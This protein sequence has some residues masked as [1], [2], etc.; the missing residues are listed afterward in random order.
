MK[1]SYTEQ[2]AECKMLIDKHKL[3]LKQI[4]DNPHKEPKDFVRMKFLNGEID[5][6]DGSLQIKKRRLLNLIN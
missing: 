5:E 6:E 3:E 4:V 2:L 1:L